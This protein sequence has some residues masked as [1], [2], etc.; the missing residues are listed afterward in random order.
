VKNAEINNQALP[1]LKLLL[2]EDNQE[3]VR[4][5]ESWLPPD[6]PILVHSTNYRRADDLVQKLRGARFD[7]TR[8]PFSILHQDNMTEWLIG[9]RDIWEDR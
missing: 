4:L 9:V 5:I 7:V 6:V 2:I 1:L 8:I 3:R